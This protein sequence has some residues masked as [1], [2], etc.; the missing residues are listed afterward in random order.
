MI[1]DNARSDVGCGRFEQLFEGLR[2]NHL[3]QLLVIQARTY[4]G[5]RLRVLRV[6]VP[7]VLNLLS[8]F[9]ERYKGIRAIRRIS[10]V[11]HLRAIYKFMCWCL[12]LYRTLHLVCNTCSRYSLKSLLALIIQLDRS[13]LVGVVQYIATLYVLFSSRHPILSHSIAGHID[14]R[15][16]VCGLLILGPNER[17]IIGIYGA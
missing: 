2:R 1:L 8:S 7:A 11:I 10:K 16:R 12:E 14:R 5:Q 13:L 9:I 3:N 6:F 17:H 4:F 15:I